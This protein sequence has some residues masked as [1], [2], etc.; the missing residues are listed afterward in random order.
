MK[1]IFLLLLIIASITE[2]CKKYEDGPW[3]SFRS[4][5][6]RF[7]KC[8]NLTLVKYNIN[9]VDSLS[10]F[11]D[12]LCTQ[13]RFYYDDVSGEDICKIEGLRKDGVYIY[14]A[15]NWKLS[16][17]NIIWQQ[18]YSVGNIGIGPFGK[19]KNNI[20]WEILK[21]KSKDKIFK[22]NYNGKEYLIELKSE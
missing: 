18:L 3:I 16:E 14:I 20:D 11:N 5:K 9:G 12:S 2:G 21:L 1:K 4:P 10:L 19:D 13:L 15:W 8:P 17:N 22:T 7:Y 6:E